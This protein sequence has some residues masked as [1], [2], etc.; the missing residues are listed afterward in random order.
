MQRSRG[1][2][3]GDIRPHVEI[4][5][6]KPCKV[7]DQFKRPLHNSFQSRTCQGEFR[8]SFIVWCKI[9]SPLISEGMK[10]YVH[11]AMHCLQKRAVNNLNIGTLHR[12]WE[13]WDG[14]VWLPRRSIKV[15]K[16]LKDIC[17]PTKC[18]FSL[19]G[20]TKTWIGWCLVSSD[21]LA[22]KFKELLDCFWP[23]Y[24]STNRS[25]TRKTVYL[26][27]RMLSL[28]RNIGGK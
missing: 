21:V 19:K 1:R 4:R 8:R 15:S 6:G 14:F 12:R 16:V 10:L 17:E 22:E 3:S 5:K 27:Q 9:M 23:R 26:W 20:A 2:N 25:G 13:N 24:V 11:M 18:G 7:Q 28:S